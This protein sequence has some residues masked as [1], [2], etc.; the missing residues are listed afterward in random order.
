MPDGNRIPFNLQSAGLFVNSTIPY[1]LGATMTIQGDGSVDLR[2]KDGTIYRF[3]PSGFQL[4][5]LL[6]SITD[7]NRN[8]VTLTRN[9]SNLIQITQIA[10]PVGRSLTLAYDSS[11][12]ITSVT[13]PIGRTVQYTY[14][15]Q[16]T[17][18]TVTDPAR[19]LTQYAYDSQNNL[20]SVTDAR[21]RRHRRDGPSLAAGAAG[22]TGRPAGGVARSAD[23][24]A[25]SEVP[26]GL[27]R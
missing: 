22:G 17:L 14:N 5:S 27:F 10:D 1:F 6:A 15:S 18:A 26:G 4:G 19:G 24:A 3:V 13:D 16:G 11:N 23:A 21:Q 9:P 12:R 8:A 20:T 2:Y 25:A 7:S